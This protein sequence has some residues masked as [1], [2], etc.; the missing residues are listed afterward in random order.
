MTWREALETDLLKRHE[1]YER[2]RVLCAEDYRDLWLRDR[3]R[4]IVIRLAN[5]EPAIDV[6]ASIRL[7]LSRPTNTAASKPGGCCGGNPYGG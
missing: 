2:Y 3:Y 4:E 1:A 7:A 6:D 5:S